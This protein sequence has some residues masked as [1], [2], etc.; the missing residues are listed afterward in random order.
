VLH[1]LDFVARTRAKGDGAGRIKTAEQG[2]A[3]SV[4]LATSP[5][6]EGIGG[7][8]FEDCN[9]A[10]LVTEHGSGSGGVAP[11][12]LDPDNADW[13]WETSLRLVGDAVAQP[14]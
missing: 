4:L 13:L 10:E 12:A 14:C 6:L 5:R 7:R 2:A 11:Y 1:R 8:C 3:T 9:E